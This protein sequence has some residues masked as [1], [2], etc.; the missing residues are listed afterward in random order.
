MMALTLLVMLAVLISTSAFRLSHKPLQKKWQRCPTTVLSSVTSSPTSQSTYTS[1][2]EKKTFR[3]QGIYDISYQHEGDSSA[4]PLLL[5]HGFGA[6]SGHFRYNIPVLSK[7]H[8]VFAIDLLG[9]GDSSKPKDVTFSMELLRD[10]CAD[11]MLEM[12]GSERKWGVGGNSIGGLC[13]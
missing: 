6:S 13:R 3:Y 9:F 12:G 1:S 8:N 2:A 4:P 7:T 11:F 5:I 10:L